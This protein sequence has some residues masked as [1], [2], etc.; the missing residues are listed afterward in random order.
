[1]IPLPAL[2]LALAAASACHADAHAG[3]ADGGEPLA[4]V[5]QRYASMQDAEVRFVQTSPGQQ[6]SPAQGAEMVLQAKKPKSYRLETADQSIVT[7][8]TT[9][10]RHNR[11]TNQVLVDHYRPEAGSLS[12]ERILSGS[13]GDVVSRTTGREVRAG[14]TLTLVTLTP[15]D[16]TEAYRSL[17]LWVDENAGVIRK[18]EATD[19]TGRVTVITVSDI[20]FDTGLTDARFTFQPPAGAT[21]VDL[22]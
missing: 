22:R 18:L 8:G 19:V 16:D 13:P 2:L 10:W 14:R 17:T 9:V 3:Q 15:M 5:R 21:V 12:P 20:R 1:M 7:D 6:G 11:R 4:R